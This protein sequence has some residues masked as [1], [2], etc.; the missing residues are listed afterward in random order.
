[1]ARIDLARRA[2][3]GR[4]RRARTRSQLIEAARALYGRSPIEAVTVDD[5]VAEA[6][7]AKGTFYV[8]FDGLAELQ[9]AVADELAQEFDE[10][11]QPRRLATQDPIERIAAGCGAFVGEALRN[12]AWGALV[13]RGAV[14]MPNIAL[15]PRD[16]LIEDIRRAAASGRLGDVTPELAFEFAVGIVL[17]AM[18]AASERRIAPSQAPSVVAGILR[19][20]GVK[21]EEAKIVA[22][23]VDASD[24]RMRDEPPPT[25]G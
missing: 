23:R 1:M 17:Q 24:R 13:A 4:D 21:P 15:V 5:V 2:Q 12:P 22:M 25:G 7:V 19:A 3:I 6:A 18:Q 20:I 11:L 10:L 8:H 9:A 14:S 16:R